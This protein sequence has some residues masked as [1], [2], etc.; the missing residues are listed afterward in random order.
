MHISIDQVS[1]GPCRVSPTPLAP[2]VRSC[3]DPR[4][5][6]RPFVSLC[7]CPLPPTSGRYTVRSIFMCPHLLRRLNP[8]AS[9]M[10][11]PG[12][13][14]IRQ[15]GLLNMTVHITEMVGAPLGGCRRVRCIHSCSLLAHRDHPTY[16]VRTRCRLQDVKVPNSTPARLQAQAQVYSDILQACLDNSNCKSFEVV[17]LCQLGRAA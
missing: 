12:S 4:C 11:L 13:E 17:R 16:P 5:A 6:C 8:T 10:S 3:T 9:L 1:A 7:R 14:N 15:L 2:D